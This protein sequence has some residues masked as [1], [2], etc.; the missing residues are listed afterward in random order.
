L[1]WRSLVGI[2]GRRERKRRKCLSDLG[3]RGRRERKRRKCPNCTWLIVHV[4][5]PRT[6]FTSTKKRF[7]LKT[8]FVTENILLLKYFC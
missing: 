7:L 6:S 5:L 1:K 2:R 3:I 4:T 8:V